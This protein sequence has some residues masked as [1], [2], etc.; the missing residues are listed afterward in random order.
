MSASRFEQN[1]DSLESSLASDIYSNKLI[2]HGSKYKFPDYDRSTFWNNFLLEADHTFVLVGHTNKSWV[3][4]DQRQCQLL[5]DSIIRI[6]RDGGTVRILSCTDDDVISSNLR[7]IEEW[8]VDKLNG[9]SSGMVLRAK[10]SVEYATF[11]DINYNAVVSDDRLV[12]IPRSNDK[13]FRQNDA[14]IEV[15]PIFHNDIY[16]NYMKDIDSTFRLAN[17]IQIDW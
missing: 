6:I 14:V 2:L 11:D 13:D 17:E 12:V 1:I 8:V 9:L 15:D 10:D 5:S 16:T 7:F 4:G 3:K